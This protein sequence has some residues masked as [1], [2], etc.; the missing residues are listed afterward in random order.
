MFP[1]SNAD[2]VWHLPPA[3]ARSVFS[4]AIGLPDLGPSSNTSDVSHSISLYRPASPSS[5]PACYKID[6]VGAVPVCVEI[7]VI[8]ARTV[9]TFAPSNVTIAVNSVEIHL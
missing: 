7:G 4:S 1:S 3:G 9:A 5:P 2:S 6:G 8:K